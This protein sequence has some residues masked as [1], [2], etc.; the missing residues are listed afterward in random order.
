MNV[1][2]HHSSQDQLH[3][4]TSFCYDYSIKG[5]RVITFEGERTVQDIIQFAEKANRYKCILTGRV[6][7]YQG[8]LR[9][10]TWAKK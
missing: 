3:M 4:L 10:A 8:K 9:Q 6:R 2:L 1:F 5:Q 7:P